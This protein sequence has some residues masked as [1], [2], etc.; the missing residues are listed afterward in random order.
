[1]IAKSLRSAGW[2]N[3]TS[4]KRASQ[5]T[6]SKEKEEGGWVWNPNDEI[7]VIVKRNKNSERK[8]I[9]S[10]IKNKNKVLGKRSVCKD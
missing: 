6:L 9:F 3:K 4:V 8:D 1:M 10:K 5:V 2:G 7:N